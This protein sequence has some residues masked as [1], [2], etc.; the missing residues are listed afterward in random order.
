MTPVLMRARAEL[1][2]RWR[3]WVSLAVMLGNFGGAVIAIAAGSRRIDTTY[4]RFLRATRAWD[5]I[6]PNFT[7]GAANSSLRPVDLCRIERLPQVQ[8]SVRIALVALMAAAW[9]AT[10]L[11]LVALLI[12]LPAGVAAGR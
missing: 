6:V 10:T 3:A 11:S 12:G 5:V 2:T 9:Q 4:P 8:E 1:R 7:F